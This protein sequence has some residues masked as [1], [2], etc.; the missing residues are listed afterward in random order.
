MLHRSLAPDF[1]PTLRRVLADS[2]RTLCSGRVLQ[3]TAKTPQLIGKLAGIKTI[4]LVQNQAFTKAVSGIC[5][6][7]VVQPGSQNGAVQF[8]LQ[9]LL[10][11]SE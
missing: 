7:Q 1:S 6:F 10:S 11:G 9:A 3:D 5:C 2:S 8:Q 4:P